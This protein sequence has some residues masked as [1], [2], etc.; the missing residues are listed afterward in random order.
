MSRYT[1]RVTDGTETDPEAT[2]GFDPP[3][4]T[5]FLQAFPDPDTDECTLWL[6]TGLE[7]FPTLES[8]IEQARHQGYE[9]GD[10]SHDII[11]GM[12]K[13][14]GPLYPPS[15]GERLGIVK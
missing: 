1:V 14:A 5:F 15:L 11:V 12:L 6:G 7:E 10:L 2:I 3:L 8:I 4:R 13:D 9:I